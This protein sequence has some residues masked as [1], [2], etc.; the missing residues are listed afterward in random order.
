MKKLLYKFWQRL[1]DMI[2]RLLRPLLVIGRLFQT[3][4]PTSESSKMIH[5]LVAVNITETNNPEHIPYQKVDESPLVSIIVTIHN[6]RSFL[7]SCLASIRQ[8]SFK[9]WECII[10]DDAS[11]DDSLEIARLHS[12]ED[13]R[14]LVTRR[15]QNVGLSEARNTGIVLARGEYITFL[16]GD[17][18][19]FPDTLGIRYEKACDP[20]PLIAGSWC[21]WSLVDEKTRIDFPQPESSRGNHVIDY[22]TGEGEN[23]VISSSPLIKTKIM[24][25]LDGYDSEFR[26]GEDFE[27]ITRL[28]RNGFRLKA[29]GTTGIAY[30]QKR[31]SMVVD[32][33][34]GHL[35]NAMKVYSYMDSPLATE[36]ICVSASAP[37]IDPPKGI[38]SETKRFER[39]VTFLALFALKN[40]HQDIPD[41]RNEM[42]G[43][44]KGVR[45]SKSQI[46]S[47]IN[48]ALRRNQQ[49]NKQLNAVDKKRIKEKVLEQISR[50][51]QNTEKSDNQILHHVGALNQNRL[52]AL[53]QVS[54][55][56]R[57]DI[58]DAAQ[59]IP[60][61]ALLA[62]SHDAAREL[63]LVGRELVYSGHTVCM[64][65]NFKGEFSNSITAEGVIPVNEIKGQLK[66]LITSDGDTGKAEYEK[67]F[68]ISSEPTLPQRNKFE[69]DAAH[70]RGPWE[71]H[72]FHGRTL[73][74]AGWHTRQEN[75]A[76][77][78]KP[79]D[80]QNRYMKGEGILVLGPRNEIPFSVPHFIKELA[81]NPVFFSPEFEAPPNITIDLIRFRVIAPYLK[82]VVCTP[83]SI[84]ADALALGIPVVALSKDIDRYSPIH[85]VS[86]IEDLLPAINKI[87]QNNWAIEIKSDVLST[88]IDKCLELLAV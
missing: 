63:L 35:K 78:K 37:I 62:K 24:Y 48:V 19:M 27:F 52:S 7:N 53:E 56:I 31:N 74:I 72:L 46:V 13:A 77:I 44:F 86:S 17:D 43:D 40:K 9:N 55:R 79:K 61:I 70:I 49:L 11:V 45:L 42:Y 83:T 3:K 60:E 76:S 23:Q 67:H 36:S 6:D 51:Y 34:L 15:D 57:L 8:Q 87:S 12:K 20:D 18:F 28:L 16:D 25:E 33:P 68:I 82:A 59:G 73:D 65:D 84:P 69:F 54:S 1:P 22:M 47:R 26:T 85:S 41:I 5:P 21:D 10:I 2:K 50:N 88:H 66:L 75:I 81:P 58:T 38:P 80:G 4:N 64:Q 14:I 30:R 29:S 71:K 39:I 32:D